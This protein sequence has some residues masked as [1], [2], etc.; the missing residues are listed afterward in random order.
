MEEQHNNTSEYV[1]KK[2]VLKLND[3][4]RNDS[5][6]R[7]TV[8]SADNIGIKLEVVGRTKVY[9]NFYVW[10]GIRE[11]VCVVKEEDEKATE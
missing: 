5:E 7:G 1:G 2:V 10:N 3:P 4:L 11:V 6:V 8:L 9:N